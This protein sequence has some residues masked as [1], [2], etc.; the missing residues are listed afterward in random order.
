MIASIA[1]GGAVGAVLRHVLGNFVVRFWV[2]S[3][4]MGTLFV[5][6]LGCFTLGFLVS[7]L[8]LRFDM[9]PEMRSF[10]VVGILG[11]FTTFSAFSLETFAML[12]RGDYAL[13]ASYIGL[14]VLGGLLALGLG[15]F[16][17]RFVF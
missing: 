12:E 6:I 3:P 4:F 16:L 8:A 1:A 9:T 2:L 14:S 7:A 17:G 5:N 13:A 15:M 10:L 11:G